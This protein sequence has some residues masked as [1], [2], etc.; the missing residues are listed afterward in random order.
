MTEKSKKTLKILNTEVIDK[1]KDL[2][3]MIGYNNPEFDS[4]KINREL[5]MLQSLLNENVYICEID[6]NKIIPYEVLKMTTIN[7]WEIRKLDFTK[8]D[9]GCDF[10]SN[11]NYPIVT[12]QRKSLN[13]YFKKN[14]NYLYPSAFPLCD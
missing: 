8:T 6:N 14:K 5:F 1:I 4:E 11:E 2:E 13:N 12:I 3:T 9:N 10:T 7:K